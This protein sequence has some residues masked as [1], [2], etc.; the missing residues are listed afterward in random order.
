MPPWSTGVNASPSWAARGQ[1]DRGRTALHEQ[2]LQYDGLAPGLCGRGAARGAGVRRGE[3]Q[4]RFR[5]VQ[6]HSA[7][8]MRGHRRHQALGRHPRTLPPPPAETGGGAEADRVRRPHAGRHVLPL[9]P[10]SRWLRATPALLAPRTPR[11]ISFANGRS[12]PCRGTMWARSCVSPP[13]SRR[14]TR[15][16]RIACWVNWKTACVKQPCDSDGTTEA[17]PKN[18]RDPL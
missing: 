8:R 16:T 15:R 1:G 6:G 5:P 14:R 18:L 9:H 2:E 13:P 4:L 12:P 10:G 11:S 7:C 17:R 3:G